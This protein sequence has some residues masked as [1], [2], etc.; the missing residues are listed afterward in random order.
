[1]NKEEIGIVKMKRNL[2]VLMIILLVNP[3]SFAQI[4]L[5]EGTLIDESFIEIENSDEL[6]LIKDDLTKNYVLTNDIDLKD[7]EWE[8]IEGEFTGTL[9]GDEFKIKN[10]PAKY[11]EDENYGLFNKIKDINNIDVEVKFAEK[12]IEEEVEDPQIEKEMVEGETEASQAEEEMVEE[13]MKELQNE[14]KKVGEVTKDPQIKEEII[15]KKQKVKNIVA[16]M[17][18]VQ[19]KNVSTWRELREA[20]RDS[21]VTEIN[22]QNDITRAIRIDFDVAAREGAEALVINGNGNELS[23]A[24]TVSRMTFNMKGNSSG[25]A[26]NITFENIKLKPTTTSSILKQDNRVTKDFTVTFKNILDNE[27]AESTKG[28]LVDAEN[29][30]VIFK[31]INKYE[32]NGTPTII[33][34]A[35]SFTVEKTPEASNPVPGEIP[36]ESTELH[37]KGKVYKTTVEGAKIHVKPNGV[38][39]LKGSDSKESAIELRGRESE[40]L[41]EGTFMLGSERE[42]KAEDT[43]GKG[44]IELMG[45]E[46]EFNVV[47]ASGADKA[48]LVGFSQTTG[49]ILHMKSN[50]GK[51]NI[52][53]KGTIAQ[54]VVKEGNGKFDAPIHLETANNYEINV[55]DGAHFQVSKTGG[56]APGI[57]LD[58]GNNH[59]IKVTGGA[60]FSI[61]NKGNGT[62]LDPAGVNPRNQALYFNTAGISK[63][64]LPKFELQDKGSEVE[65]IADNGVA[66]HMTNGGDVEA[67][68][69]TTFIARG[70]TASSRI[71]II[72]TGGLI[73]DIGSEFVLTN[74]DYYDFRNDHPDGGSLFNVSSRSIMKGNQTNVALWE[75]G[76]NLNEKPNHRIPNV[77]YRLSGDRF[78]E[79]TDIDGDNI[80]ESIGNKN[81]MMD[82][83]RMS[84]SK[85]TAERVFVNALYQPTDADQ[86]IYAQASIEEGIYG[87]RDLYENEAE[88]EITHKKSGE[89]TPEQILSGKIQ[90]RKT[91]PEERSYKIYGKET[92]VDKNKGMHGFG[93]AEIELPKGTFL[94]AGDTIEVTGGTL[95]NQNDETTEGESIPEGNILADSRTVID[96]TPPN[97]VKLQNVK[98]TDREYLKN[99]PQTLIGSLPTKSEEEQLEVS[100]EVSDENEN[101]KNVD[102]ELTVNRDESEFA[103]VFKEKLKENDR[104]RIYLSDKGSEAPDNVLGDKGDLTIPNRPITHTNK[105]NINPKEELIYHDK[106]FKATPTLLV[107]GASGELIFESAPDNLHFDVK[108]KPYK[109]RYFVDKEKLGQ[110]LAIIDDRTSEAKKG[111]RLTA[112]M[113]E[114]LTAIDDSQNTL[115]ANLVYRKNKVDKI[116]TNELNIVESYNYKIGDAKERWDLSSDWNEEG[117]GMFIDIE[118]GALKA[119][120]Q[121]QVNWI[122]EDAP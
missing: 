112:K 88:I 84:G 64:N 118:P 2:I 10:M 36:K 61:H 90:P 27:D 22:L 87:T 122:L 95:F 67:L 44:L 115:N 48:G 62:P 46:S 3:I 55:T 120:Y 94:E 59:K 103:Y 49:S 101:I 40:V 60:K 24:N 102:G 12:I 97:P 80:A 6:D 117:D 76:S 110:P 104:V 108:I 8:P 20:L 9:I 14:E 15:E 39:V 114:P 83:S 92:L 56:L 19:S 82:Y 7:T 121:G 57:R 79:I 32:T 41:V 37:T 5:A 68:E 86:K 28:G 89:I 81:G 73:D 34:E 109:E 65:L 78:T 54:F 119:N 85:A 113:D 25:K 43:E 71:G 72:D 98:L 42:I 99:R 23:G 47:R 91:T 45:D 50:N 16:P 96:V 107:V 1:M 69:G 26:A 66:I 11:L 18:E 33:N 53:G 116:L 35:K 58:P 63:E 100:V 93:W 70:R 52:R 17:A 4:I 38:M 51:I 111:W 106:V 30:H 29:A 75:K 105:G 31:G 74:P 13:E 77:T 21:S